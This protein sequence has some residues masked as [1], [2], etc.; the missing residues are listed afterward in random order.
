MKKNDLIKVIREIVRQEIK[1]ELPNALAQVFSQ[2]MGQSQQ[3]QIHSINTVRNLPKSS[4]PIP[5]PPE[6]EG[7]M[8]EMASLKGQLQEMFSNGGS[9]KK[10]TPPP[11]S[12]PQMRQ[13]AK[14]P[15]LNE[16]LNQ[17]RGFNSSERMANRVGGMGGAMS[18]GVA[19][20]A[21]AY[22]T[23]QTSTTGVGQLMSDSELGFLNKIP[24]MPGADTPVVT[25]I[26]TG[27]TMVHEGQ[28]GGAAPLESLGQISALDL[29]NHPAL[30]DSIRGILTRDYRSL[31]KA[32]DKKR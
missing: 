30:P 2:M 12:V 32:M 9:V 3:P 6:A 25:H 26:P 16:I 23:P 11:N 10:T 27:H 17:T 13:L 18:P 14:N 21:G 28:E 20:A 29:K 15:V 4:P 7:I 24:G 1:K 22:E 31:V 5:Q 19:M 8:D